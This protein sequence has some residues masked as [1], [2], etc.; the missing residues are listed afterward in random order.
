MMRAEPLQ[1]GSD[2]Q[3][4]VMSQVAHYTLS[5]FFYRKMMQSVKLNTKAVYGARRAAG[6]CQVAVRAATALP[7]GVRVAYRDSS[8]W[9]EMYCM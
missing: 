9:N 7:T 5:T 6:R 1:C 3:G 8:I 2:T 4:L